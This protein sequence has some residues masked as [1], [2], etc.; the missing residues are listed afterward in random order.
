[1]NNPH[2]SEVKCVLV[3]DNISKSFSEV[4]DK[5]EIIKNLSLE[6]NYGDFTVIQGASG[7]GKSTLLH[8]MG[9]LDAPTSGNVY[10]QGDQVTS[11]SDRRLSAIRNRQVGFVFQFHHLMPDFNALE[12]VLMPKYI[13]G[14]VTAADRQ[15]A[16][17]LISLVHLKDRIKHLP[18]E[19]SGG[20]RQ[21]L[22]LA[23]ALINEPKFLLTDEPSGN[24]DA[25]NSDML[26]QL[27]KQVNEQLG[28]T[29][30]CVTHDPSLASLCRQVY[31]MTK[32]ALVPC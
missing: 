29:I 12:N 28:V 9:L 4:G 17:D 16:M 3:L 11:L 10:F 8:I 13:T 21:R 25:Q 19:L 2:T 30:I 22:A 6:V 26:H 7:V 18:N 1:M 14:N 31:T 15:K 32:G 27:L 24:L 20:E 23:R 5:L